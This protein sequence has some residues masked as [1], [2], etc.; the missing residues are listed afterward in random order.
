MRKLI[1]T[2][3]VVMAL[4]SAAAPQAS[5]D[6]FQLN[7]I[8]CNCLPAG[9]TD[10]GSVTLT[11]VGNNVQFVV[12]LNDLLNF[13]LTNAFD[14]FAFNYGGSYAES[15]FS[16]SGLPSGWALYTSPQGS[17][18]MD[19]AGK[20]YDMFLYCP[21]CS[22]TG[23]VSGVNSVTFL[24]SSSGGALTLANFETRVGDTGSSNNNFAASV[25]RIGSVSGCT[26]VIGGG[27]GTG[28]STPQAST[29]LA[30]T[31]NCGASVP[32]GGSVAMMLGAALVGL[33]GLR[34]LMK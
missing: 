24:L 32:D 4:I 25:T 31:V 34:R 5:A 26:G 14:L 17:G 29:G 13:H 16:V 9:S 1:V 6:T 12:D 3:G 2:C 8:Y 30:G 20:N 18:S 33:A 22:A 19:G 7:D 15:T 21:T 11:Q 10:G 27:D 28:Q 23:G